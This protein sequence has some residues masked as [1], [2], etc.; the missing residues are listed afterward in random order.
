[1][2]G[3]TSNQTSSS[4]S[5][6]SSS[7]PTSTTAPFVFGATSATT[8]ATPRSQS[9]G[10]NPGADSPGSTGMDIG[11]GYASG[12]ASNLSAPQMSNTTTAGIG[13]SSSLVSVPGPFGSSS[14]NP[15]GGLSSSSAF[16]AGS[17]GPFGSSQGMAPLPVTG[18][19]GSQS[20][21][22]QPPSSIGSIGQPPSSLG[23]IGQLP[24]SL[25][26]IGQ[27][28]V[29][30]SSI[31]QPPLSLSSIG[32]PPVS[33]SSIGQ[34]PVSLGSIGQPPLSLG[35]IGQPPVSLSS[36]GSTNAGGG[37]FFGAAAN[38][39]APGSFSMG[40]RKKVTTKLKKK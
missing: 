20:S 21:M 39:A 40:S 27:P 5:S 1:M 28:P 38:P 16:G 14:S 11:G 24:L 3:S 23:S 36:F 31:G 32:Q 30:L 22:G 29:S 34:P 13:F 33:L 9:I 19:L 10:S 26:S 6:S 15:F 37:Q 25:G 4:S 2:F 18:S 8:L 35:S 12:D 7:I 17:S